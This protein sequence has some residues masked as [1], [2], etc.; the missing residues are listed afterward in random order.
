MGGV[1][2]RPEVIGCGDEHGHSCV[3]DNEVNVLN[4]HP[5]LKSGLD[6]VGKD[7][8]RGAAGELGT[9][10]GGAQMAWKKLAT[11][12]EETV[13]VATLDD[14]RPHGCQL[15]R[16]AKFHDRRLQDGATMARCYWR[17]RAAR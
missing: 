3:H 14:E 17:L 5:K 16:L 1:I 2:T 6:M 9:V 10:S 12:E 8:V 11:T 4:F 15:P 7:M 13:V